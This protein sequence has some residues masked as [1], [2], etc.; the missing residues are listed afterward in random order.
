MAKPLTKP[1]LFRLTLSQQGLQDLP[2]AFK[3]RSVPPMN[4]RTDGKV[5]VWVSNGLVDQ[6]QTAARPKEN[7]SDAVTRLARGE[8]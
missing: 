5:D 7:L 8:K 4:R 1:P 3:L 2:I 6:L